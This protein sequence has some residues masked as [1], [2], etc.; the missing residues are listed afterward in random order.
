M[1]RV[2]L[3][4]EVDLD[5]FRVAARAAFAAGIAPQA[6]RFR[7]GA[8]SEDLFAREEEDAAPAPSCGAAGPRA[9]RRFLDLLDQVGRHRDPERF[10]LLYAALWRLRETPGLLDVASDPLTRRL[11]DM[12]R[13]TRRDRHKMT[14]FVR[15]REI[16]EPQGARFVAW[17]EPE[18]FIEEWAAPFF[19]DRFASM[20]FAI[21][22]PR[23][24][25]L[26][27]EGALS[28][29]PG[30]RAPNGGDE[31]NDLAEADAFTQRWNAYYRSVFN[32]ARLSPKA[33]L[34]EMPK[35]YWRNLPEARQAPRMI[36]Q[37]RGREAALLAAPPAPA[38]SRAERIAAHVARKRAQPA[39]ADTLDALRAQARDCRRCPLGGCATQT[40]F[41]EGPRA[42][43]AILVGEQ[44]GD[45]EDLVGRPF[46]GPAGGVL[47]AALERAGLDRGSLYLTNA[48]KHFKHE[49][50][51]KRRL[52]KTPDKA[53]IELCRWWLDQELALVAAPVVVAL[54]ASAVRALTGDAFG[55]APL[56][57]LRERDLRLG[58]RALIVTTHTSFLLRLPDADA[59]ARETERFV[60]D[61]RR[62]GAA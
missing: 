37:A 25:I 20:R 36:A 18:H 19:V 38:S 46:V 11:E 28:F 58:G 32:P 27:E 35:R 7:V 55:G 26:W 24:S 4:H 16:P 3:A 5:G 62:A 2:R 30:G 17:F 57:A 13:A 33:M 14:A 52:H 54:G 41:G 40:V 43:R 59:R 1:R 10:D 49:P 42:A 23:R 34:K 21:V 6:I 39:P 22:T 44:P 12:A 60:A 45:R 50:R 15:F 48:V 56:S 8:A 53:E 9:P 47:D 61:L 51:G 29:G 31:L